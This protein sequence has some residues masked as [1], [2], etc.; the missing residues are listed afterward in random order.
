M[1]LDEPWKTNIGCC[2][3][4]VGDCLSKDLTAETR[5][6]A[7]SCALYIVVFRR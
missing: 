5:H 2:G 6:M 1:G 7:G 4:V 3:D